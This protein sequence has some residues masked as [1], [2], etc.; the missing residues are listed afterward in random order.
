[1]P[2]KIILASA[3]P[4]R[5]ELLTLAGIAF[6]LCVPAVDETPKKG[7]APRALVKRLAL[8]K[9]KAVAQ[10]KTTTMVAAD[11]IVAIGKR[12]LGKPSDDAEAAAMVRAVSGGWHEVLTGFC[13]LKKGRAVTRV[14]TTRVRFRSLSTAD[15]S[16]YIASGEHR[17]KA[18]AYAI[19]GDGT[20][21]VAEVRGSLS[22]VIGLPLAEVLELLA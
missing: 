14:V 4:R 8:K 11:T 3:S 13:V 6:E 7:E 15:I 1:M 16:R 21:L 22:N 9:A 17:D 20:A 19:Q 10:K 12:P 2:A 5:R 18:G